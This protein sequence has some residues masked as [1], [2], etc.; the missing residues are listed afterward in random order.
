MLSHFKPREELFL[1]LA[2]SSAA[3]STTLVRE[4]DKVQKPIYYTSQ[5]LRGAEERYPLMEKLTFALVTVACKLKPY[6][7]AHTVVVLTDKHLRPAMSN[8]EAVG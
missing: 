4:E 2:I 5:A 1:Y 7:Q 6:F 8:L 3:V